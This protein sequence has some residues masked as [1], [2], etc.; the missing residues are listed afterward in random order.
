MKNGKNG[1]SGI[2][3][4][5]GLFRNGT[6]HVVVSL[7]SL[8][9]ASYQRDEIKKHVKAIADGFEEDAAQMVRISLRAGNLWCMDGRQTISAMLQRTPQ[10]TEWDAQLFT[11]LTFKKEAHL[12]YKWNN[13]R[14]AM[15]GWK[16]FYADLNGGNRN[17]K[18]IVDI[19]HSYKL[20]IPGDTGVD[21]NKN[22]DISNASTLNNSYDKGGLMLVDKY[23]QVIAKAWKKNGIVPQA[24]KELSLTRGMIAFLNDTDTIGVAI[25]T[26]RVIT[27]EQIRQ[28]ANRMTSKGRIDAAQMRQAFEQTIRIRKAA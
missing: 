4:E 8:C 26:L 17:K 12:F 16:N 9:F 5:V 10:I 2:V 1:A 13:D 6:R 3:E 11:G 25:N 18:K 27:P 23:C 15:S 14:K 19:V 21:K 24:A 22:A 20:T 7:K 28:I